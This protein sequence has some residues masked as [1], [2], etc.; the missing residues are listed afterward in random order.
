MSPDQTQ[1]A[2]P[3]GGAEAAGAPTGRRPSWKVLTLARRE[4]GAYFLS[5]MAYII[6]A[7]F[8]LATGLFFFYRVFTPGNE[9]S[10]RPLFEMMAYAM[11]AAGPMLTMR[12]M[13]EEYRSGTIETLMTAPL[14]DSE[15]IL[16]KF[17]GVMGF[18]L[19]LLACTVVFMALMVIYGQPDAGVAIVGYAGMIL[20]GAAYL[21]VGL[22]ASTM[23]RYQV[24]GALVGIVVLAFFG[25]LMPLVV[26]YGGEPWNYV[27]Q[28]LNAMTY[29]TDFARGVLD[30]RGVVF[31][32]GATAMALFLSV[33]ILESRRWR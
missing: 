9:A 19:A 17:L 10:L 6:G 22:L 12:L 1:D 20:L 11:I 24:I 31:F 27:A 8:V 21:A 25:A 28:K 13:S 3:A 18:Y 16:G 2:I 29:F 26:A 33:K 15:V 23:T 30:T 14:R 32:L 7:M 4:L 5:P